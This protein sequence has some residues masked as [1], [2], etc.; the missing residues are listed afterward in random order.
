M[1][2]SLA[3]AALVAAA[4]IGGAVAGRW[5]ARFSSASLAAVA[6]LLLAVVLGDLVPDIARDA[7]DIGV[8]LAAAAG[9]AGFGLAG[10]ALRWGCACE[11]PPAG[12]VAAA[13]AI[14]VH[15]ALEG[16]ALAIT[17]SVWL[18]AA[19]VLHA[20]SEG[21]ALAT[22]TRSAPRARGATLLLIACASPLVGA[23]ALRTIGLPD[24]AGS[25]V[26]AVVAG[27]L[28][29]SALAAHRLAVA[30]G[31][32]QARTVTTLTAACVA[33]TLFGLSVASA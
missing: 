14:G 11:A 32:V 18:I 20:G 4:T 25:I 12:G 28:A 9:V 17:T 27:A 1:I 29:R 22:L 15:R 33:A 26:T 31:A 16:S 5:S 19:L 23:V 24:Q 13:A 6:G 7:G 21:Y 30:R 2:A 8:W 10:F 3:G